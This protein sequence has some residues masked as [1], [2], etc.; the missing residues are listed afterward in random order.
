MFYKVNIYHIDYGIFTMQRKGYKRV[1]MCDIYQ[2][3]SFLI[4]FFFEG[5]LPSGING[6]EQSCRITFLGSCFLHSGRILLSDKLVISGRKCTFA[7][8]KSF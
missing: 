6:F 2:K 5:K 7:F 4:F 8:M 1:N 3:N